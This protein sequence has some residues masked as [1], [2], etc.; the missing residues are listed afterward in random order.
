MTGETKTKSMRGQNKRNALLQT[1]WEVFSEQGYQSASMDMVVAKAGGSKQTLYNYFKSKEELLR[2]VLEARRVELDEK[3]YRSFE[4][5]GDLVES[6]WNFGVQMMDLAVN[7][8]L[9]ELYRIAIAESKTLALGEWLY[10]CGFADSW[11]YMAA[12]LEKNI[13]P[14]RLMDGGGWTAAM[15]LRGLLDG[16]IVLRSLCGV[17]G[18]M[19]REDIAGRVASGLEAFFRV[20]APE[21]IDVLHR[22]KQVRP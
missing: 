12:Y 17:L 19:T 22:R 1:A 21:K 6:L 11:K 18:G 13:D 15:H 20:Y 16:D 9:I 3:V 14:S 5:P 2:A 10:K 8:D 4:V 7:S